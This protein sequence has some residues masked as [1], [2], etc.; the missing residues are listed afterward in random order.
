[1]NKWYGKV[2]Y[3]NLVESAPDVWTEQITE[4]MYPGEIQRLGRRLQ[5]GEA[6]NDGVQI[7]NQ[8]S[9]LADPYAYSHFQNIRYV[10]FWGVKWKVTNIDVQTPRLVFTLGEEYHDGEE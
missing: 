10:E 2:G 5:T 3:A 4:R 8:I 7:T 6:I 1:M 9:I